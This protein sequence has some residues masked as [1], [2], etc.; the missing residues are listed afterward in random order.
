MKRFGKG[1][2]YK[3]KREVLAGGKQGLPG[4]RQASL[5]SKGTA[6][7]PVPMS[8]C[9]GQRAKAVESSGRFLE[10]SFQEK[11]QLGSI[12]DLHVCGRREGIV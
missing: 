3:A 12:C 11:E 4:R 10:S 5:G 8:F 2:P 1:W 7:V 6:E 9:L